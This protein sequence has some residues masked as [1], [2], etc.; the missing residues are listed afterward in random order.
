MEKDVMHYG[1]KMFLYYFEDE[2]FESGKTASFKEFLNLLPQKDGYN[3]E[4]EVLEGWDGEPK[5]NFFGY[6]EKSVTG[7]AN[8][9]KILG[10]YIELSMKNGHL[11][12]WKKITEISKDVVKIWKKYLY[13]AG[14][15]LLKELEIPL[16]TGMEIKRLGKIFYE[17]IVSFENNPEYN[18]IFERFSYEAKE[19]KRKIK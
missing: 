6:K 5:M 13:E 7:F 16:D 4:Y 8:P 2:N 17:K 18:E 19:L 10:R 15:S 9:A 14:F 1:L 12:D 3:S 11:I